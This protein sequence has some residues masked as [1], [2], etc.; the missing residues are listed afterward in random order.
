[1]T[2]QDEAKKTERVSAAVDVELKTMIEQQR[3]PG[4]YEAETVRRILRKGLEAEGEAETSQHTETDAGTD[5]LGPILSWLASSGVFVAGFA[6]TVIAVTL[7]GITYLTAG[8]VSVE[9][10]ILLTV[11]ATVSAAIGAPM[12]V[13]NWAA[14]KVQRQPPDADTATTESAE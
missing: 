3:E 4:E 1:M 12:L 8:S 9:V 14:T 11:L 2:D 6:A 5:S 7:I 10:S 13:L